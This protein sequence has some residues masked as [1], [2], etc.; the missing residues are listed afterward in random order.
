MI[1]LLERFSTGASL[2]PSGFSVLCGRLEPELAFASA[3]ESEGSIF[4][5]SHHGSRRFCAPSM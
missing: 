4:L 1:E 5:A 3:L 2:P